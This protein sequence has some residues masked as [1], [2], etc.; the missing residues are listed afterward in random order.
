MHIHHMLL[1]KIFLYI[2]MGDI[3]NA[4]AV[5]FN[6]VKTRMAEEGIQS[7]EINDILN[8]A[9]NLATAKVKSEFQTPGS[10]SCD[11]NEM[12]NEFSK[13]ITE[14]NKLITEEDYLN[15]HVTLDNTNQIIGSYQKLFEKLYNRMK[16]LSDT[17]KYENN[18]LNKNIDNT[19]LLVNTNKRKAVYER[20]Q[21]DG[22]K[23]YR[24][25]LLITFY[26]LLVVYLIFGNFRPSRLYRNRM[27]MYL[28]IPLIIL[29]LVVKYVI[30]FIYYLTYK[31]SHF[32]NNEAP[33]NVYIEI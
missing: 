12:V 10:S 29:P 27:F 28:F 21:F 18:D 20:H 14:N 15:I 4:A 32:L 24:I 23:I 7:Q 26:G 25:A 11:Y 8:K 31:I 9:K 16:E 30:R 3:D 2:N 19:K 6:D 5:A 13:I 1:F 22:L 33:K 17:R